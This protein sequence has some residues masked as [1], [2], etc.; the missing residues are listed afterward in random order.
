MDGSSGLTYQID[1]TSPAKYDRRG[2]LTDEKANRI[3]NVQYNGKPIDLKQ[4]FIIIT[5]SF[6]RHKK[7]E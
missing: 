7:G 6:N 2:N 5:N 1:V 3:K 4:E